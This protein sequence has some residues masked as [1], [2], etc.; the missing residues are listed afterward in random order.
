M[1]ETIK[2]AKDTIKEKAT[3]KDKAAQEAFT[4]ATSQSASASDTVE[5]AKE[6]TKSAIVEKAV[7][8]VKANV[9][10]EAGHI[11]DTA[12]TAAGQA[13]LGTASAFIDTTSTALTQINRYTPDVYDVGAYGQSD[14]TSDSGMFIAGNSAMGLQNSVR[15]AAGGAAVATAAVDAVL[16]NEK[17]M[18]KAKEKAEEVFKRNPAAKLST[19]EILSG[20]SRKDIT[21]YSDRM[22]WNRF[23]ANEA[24]SL[25]AK[26]RA[27]AMK[28][29]F[30]GN[31]YN[32]MMA[33]S[34][35]LQNSSGYF[36][37]RKFNL[38]RSL[39]GTVWNQSR[40]MTN[41]VLQGNDAS[42]TAN[43]AVWATVK[44]AR[45]V[46]NPSAQAAKMAWKVNKQ[47]FSMIRHPIRTVK[48][49]INA[50]IS[51]I[52]AIF[53][54]IATIPVIAS[55]IAVLAPLIVVL[56]CV[57][58]IISSLAGWFTT[59]QVYGNIDQIA[60]QDYAANAF[61]YEAK[62]RNWKNEAIV[63]VLAYM[64]GEGLGPMGT[65]TY[66]SY[67]CVEGP[68]GTTYDTTTDNDKW[69]TWMEGTGKE[70][71]HATSSYANSKYYA[72]FGIGLLQ[73]TDTWLTSSTKGSLN[74][75]A[76]ILYAKEKN[77]PW[78]DPE[79]QFAYFF[80]K[81]FSTTR[82]WDTPTLDPTKDSLS[83]EQWCRQITAGYGMPGYTAD[84]NND[85][86]AA[87]VGHVSQAQQYL[88]NYKSFS[89]LSMSS[90][91]LASSPNT[92]NTDVWCTK[93]PYDPSFR[94]QCTWFAWGRFYEIYG[95]DPGFMNYPDGSG[96]N[97]VNN[98]LKSHPDKFKYSTEPAAGAV[99]STGGT[100]TNTNH[101][102]IVISVS[103]DNV[104]VQEGNVS[105]IPWNYPYASTGSTSNG[106]WTHT[107]T[108]SY[109]Q[110][111]YGAIYAVPK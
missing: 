59:R 61:I 24:K 99:F 104:T 89:Y 98:L 53:S 107:Y 12:T 33:R 5:V 86:M 31:R 87:H 42:G 39:S 67:W 22:A 102:G 32:R 91:D 19:A 90:G 97:C 26:S 20:R 2:N 54:F 6:T 74:A 15:V 78:Q 46:T 77:M 7:D 58:T 103:G 96:Y 82:A 48:M 4:E 92:S 66:E 85:Y 45:A 95:Y 16:Y 1:D 60:T 37:R 71:M 76:L 68:G 10:Y 62:K 105:G 41:Q 94:G 50:V 75:T 79:T 9:V 34:N 108:K 111:C 88:N 18:Q 25:S 55:I 93:N 80:E 21:K 83:A 43:R 51:A 69:M 23:K 49:V 106:W 57:T 13:T 47:I 38:R 29:R 35:M 28:D 8:S 101:V 64:L 17:R 11:I 73:D 84:M 81:V 27:T 56:I 63:G 52:S 70:S 109:M 36:N 14:L 65:F 30:L 44:G 110:S 100:G 3:S 40:K 72:A